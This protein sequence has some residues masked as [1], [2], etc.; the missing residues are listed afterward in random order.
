MEDFLR[1]DV[2]RRISLREIREISSL[3]TDAIFGMS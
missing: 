3:R 2:S 1:E